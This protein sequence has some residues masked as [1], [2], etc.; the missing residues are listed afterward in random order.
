MIAMQAGAAI[1]GAQLAGKTL[2]LVAP[3]IGW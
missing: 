3:A 2:R 1:S